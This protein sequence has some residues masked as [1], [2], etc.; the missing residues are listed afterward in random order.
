MVSLGQEVRS[1]EAGQF[2]VRSPEAAVRCHP[3][4]HLAPEET[5][6]L[7]TGQRGGSLTS[8]PRGLL[9]R[10]TLETSGQRAMQKIHNLPLK[11]CFGRKQFHA[12]A[13]NE[14]TVSVFPPQKQIC[15]VIY[16]INTSTFFQRE[17]RSGDL[18]G[19]MGFCKGINA[20]TAPGRRQ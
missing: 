11:R 16:T 9:H 13:L 7:V 20:P 2:W 15:T 14:V 5:S 3:K 1:S 19:N 8:S 4:A 12:C 17:L 10:T 6:P 18:Q